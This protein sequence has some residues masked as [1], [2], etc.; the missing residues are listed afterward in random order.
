MRGA[1][2]HRK[3]AAGGRA[4][5]ARAQDADGL[6]AHLEAHQAGQRVIARPHADVGQVQVPARV[7][8]AAEAGA[9][10]ARMRRRVACAGSA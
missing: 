10:A 5:G 8:P 3:D 4:D 2:S 6:A 9:S 7:A 1:R